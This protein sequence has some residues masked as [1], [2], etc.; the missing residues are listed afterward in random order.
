MHEQE[1]NFAVQ[2]SCKNRTP[3]HERQLSASHVVDSGGRESNQKMKGC[4][5]DSRRHAALESGWS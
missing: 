1:H 3:P 4:T 5:E 2:K